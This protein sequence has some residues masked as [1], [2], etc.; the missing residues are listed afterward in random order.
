MTPEE[1]QAIIHSS[2]LIMTPLCGSPEKIDR[3]LSMRVYEADV[4]TRYWVVAND[5][6][7]AVDALREFWE[8]DYRADEEARMSG[9]LTI[10]EVSEERARKMVVQTD[11]PAGSLTL[12]WDAARDAKGPGVIGCSEWP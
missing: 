7:E 10:E 4:G 8:K 1:K 2:S 12:L 5:L 3:R 6:Y 11:A 9:S